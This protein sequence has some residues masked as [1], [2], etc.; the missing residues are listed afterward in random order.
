MAMPIFLVSCRP[1]AGT[2]GGQLWV[3]AV[4]RAFA[5]LAVQRHIPADWKAELADPQLTEAERAAIKIR[6]GEVGELGFI[7]ALSRRR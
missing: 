2:P 7:Q 4:D 5:V 1:P 3:A 6:L